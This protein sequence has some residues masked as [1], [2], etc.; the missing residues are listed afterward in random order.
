MPTV[1]TASAIMIQPTTGVRPFAE[2]APAGDG[3]SHRSGHQARFRRRPEDGASEPTLVQT[4]PRSST[5]LPGC[6]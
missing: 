4:E 1:T 3:A 6:P 2:M 5:G